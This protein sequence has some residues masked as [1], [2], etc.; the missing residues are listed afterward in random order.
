MSD[1]GIGIPADKHDAHL[2]GLRAGRH[3]DDAA[4]G[5][6]G[7]GLA[8]SSRLVELHGRPRS[9]SRARSGRGSTFHF[10]ASFTVAYREVK[11]PRVAQGPSLIGLQV[12]VVDDNATNRTILEEMLRNWQMR[13]TAV[14]GGLEAL[15]A[16]T[17]AADAGEIASRLC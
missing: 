14:A 8:I 13:P 11:Q 17:A 4:F 12:L 3:L 16:L 5:G 2:R 15:G 6:T 10:T 7:L 1:T 9:G